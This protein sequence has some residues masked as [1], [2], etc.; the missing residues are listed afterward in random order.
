MGKH[1]PAQCWGRDDAN[2]LLGV[3]KSCVLS[4]SPKQDGFRH[5]VLAISYGVLTPTL[6]RCE[7]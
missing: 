5:L 6:S 3:E 4:F 7:Y 2:D 1:A